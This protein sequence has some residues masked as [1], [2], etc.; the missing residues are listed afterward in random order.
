MLLIGAMKDLGTVPVMAYAMENVIAFYP[1][2]AWWTPCLMEHTE[3]AGHRFA[4]ALSNASTSAYQAVSE[5]LENAIWCYPDPVE[6]LAGIAGY[7]AFYGD[8]FEV[9][10][11]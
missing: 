5:K 7:V 4:E 3:G 8:R 1:D 11:R 6:N 9:T 10:A 2:G